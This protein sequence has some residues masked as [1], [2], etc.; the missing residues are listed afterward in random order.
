MDAGA[1]LSHMH[2]CSAHVTAGGKITED[3]GTAFNSRIGEPGRIM[4][5]NYG[6]RY[7]NELLT[8]RDPDRY[9]FYK[10]VI[11]YDTSRMEYPRIPSWLIFDETARQ[12]GPVVLTFYG[13]HAVGL[14][15]WS[16]DNSAEVKR[17]WILEGNS[18]QELAA[19]IASHRDNNHRMNATILLETINR[20]NENCKKKFDPDFQRPAESL[21]QLDTPPY[22]ALAQY[23]GGPNT[24][25][26]LLKNARSQ[27]LDVFGNVIPRLYAAG[28][29][30][31][32][33]NFLYQ[34]GGNLAECVIYGS[35]SG[36]NAALE[37]P[38]S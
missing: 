9:S 18:I 23:P 14:Y 22:Y 26:G 25:G 11:T 32:A 4:V 37:N 13:A 33:W 7:S 15:H 21:G 24:E 3:I 19:R 16:D 5:D 2:H 31:S 29:I 1:A 36:K 35:V 38:W 10:Q 34:A 12:K 20:F 17:G 8:S 6:R 27:V 30:A 28:E